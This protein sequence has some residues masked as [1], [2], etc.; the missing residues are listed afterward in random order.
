MSQEMDCPECGATMFRLYHI[1]DDDQI[2]ADCVGCG[3]VVAVGNDPVVDSWRQ[4]A[5]A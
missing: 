2:R 3:N 4:R 5:K 1:E